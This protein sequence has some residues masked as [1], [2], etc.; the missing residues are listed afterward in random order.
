VGNCDKLYIVRAAKSEYY[1][2]SKE[3]RWLFLYLV[4]SKIFSLQWSLH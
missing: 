1:A 3:Q 2:L 4:N